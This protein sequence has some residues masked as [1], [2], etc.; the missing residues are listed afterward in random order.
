MSD[1]FSKNL[2]NKNTCFHCKVK[3]LC[4]NTSNT[5]YIAQVMTAMWVAVDP[6]LEETME[7]SH[8]AVS[9]NRRSFVSASHATLCFWDSPRLLHVVIIFHFQCCIEF[10]SVTASQLFHP[11]LD[12]HHVSIPSLLPIV[13][14]WTFLH[15]CQVEAFDRIVKPGF[16]LGKFQFYGNEKGWSAECSSVQ[17]W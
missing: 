7:L 2:K 1:K 11:T 17:L 5:K 4:K 3:H 12:R 8:T 9:N 6:P 16:P 13:L 14:L 10:Y 15:V